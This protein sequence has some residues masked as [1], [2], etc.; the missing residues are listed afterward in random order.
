MDQHAK[1]I[2][3]MQGYIVKKKP[4]DDGTFLDE[5]AVATGDTIAKIYNGFDRPALVNSIIAYANAAG[6]INIGARTMPI[7]AGLTV[8]EN[9]AMIVYPAD[10]MSVVCATSGALFIEV[11]GKVLSGTEWSR[12]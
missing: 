7:P 11:M 5:Y 8:L 10:I 4:V 2:Q 3:Q 12:V 9:I 1:L 6:S